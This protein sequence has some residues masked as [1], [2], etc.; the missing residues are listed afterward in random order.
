MSGSLL[1][2]AFKNQQN[3][4]EVKPAQRVD[5]LMS[6]RSFMD[7]LG[8]NSLI[9]Q[10]H[11]NY[12][13]KDGPIIYSIKKYIDQTSGNPGNFCVYENESRVQSILSDNKVELD[14]YARN[15]NRMVNSYGGNRTKCSRKMKRSKRVHTSKRK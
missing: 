9:T 12:P 5:Q 7:S 2:I 6:Y 14:K 15:Q 13:S 4:F 3:M 1:F 8:S 11:F 10:I